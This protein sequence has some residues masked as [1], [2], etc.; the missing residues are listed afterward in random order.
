MIVQLT[1][2]HGS[3]M[4]ATYIDPATLLRDNQRVLSIMLFKE[5]VEHPN[6]KAWFEDAQ[7]KIIG[8][9]EMSEVK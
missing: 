3:E 2:K 4:T 7:G 9:R 8:E 6:F 5:D 1:D